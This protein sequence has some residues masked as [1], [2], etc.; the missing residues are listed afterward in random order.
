MSPPK[1][2]SPQKDLRDHVKALK[3]ER[4]TINVIVGGFPLERDNWGKTGL[5]HPN[6]NHYGYV[7]KTLTL[8]SLHKLHGGRPDP[9]HEPSRQRFGHER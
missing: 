7:K 9:R 4:G 8:K 2:S 1:I 5:H 3:E 6:I